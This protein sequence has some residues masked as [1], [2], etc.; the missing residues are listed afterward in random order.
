MA[1]RSQAGGALVLGMAAL[2]APA[3]SGGNTTAPACRL[4]VAGDTIE[5]DSIISDCAQVGPAAAD[6][7]TTGD[8]LTLGGSTPALAQ[9]SVSVPLGAAPSPGTFTSD[10]LEN[11]SAT[12]VVRG[13]ST[14]I[15]S[16]GAASVPNGN[17][18]VTLSS[19]SG[20]IA[21]GTLKA[22][23]YVHAPVYTDCGPDDVEQ[24]AL[25]F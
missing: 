4:E 25:S 17:L 12:A 11:W 15:Y 13:D 14:C 20:E 19:V 5:T 6:G 21:H 3:C 9:W 2:F 8:L 10:T 23:L 24:I 1:N 22:V 7:G 16:A 18:T